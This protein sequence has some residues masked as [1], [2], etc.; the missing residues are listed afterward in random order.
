MQMYWWRC[1]LRLSPNNSIY[2]EKWNQ[3]NVI[4][5]YTPW[6]NKNAS[7]LFGI[8][9]QKLITKNEKLFHDNN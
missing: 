6:P 3:N 8:I 1:S 9:F 4:V 5:R 7:I 2:S